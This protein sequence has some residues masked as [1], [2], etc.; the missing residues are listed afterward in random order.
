[1]KSRL[2]C[3]CILNLDTGCV[4]ETC[5]LHPTPS[6]EAAFVIRA[7]LAEH[8][9]RRTCAETPCILCK[10]GRDALASLGSFDASP[11]GS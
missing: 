2:P 7:Y 10:A 6:Q 9:Q 4:V 1:M 8:R 3:G 5:G 11:P